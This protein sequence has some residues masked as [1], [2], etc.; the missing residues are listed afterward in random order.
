MQ[1]AYGTDEAA[2]G[3]KG[4]AGAEGKAAN[5]NLYAEH[6][7]GTEGAVLSRTSNLYGMLT[8][9]DPF[10]Y[11]GGIGAAVRHLDGKA[12]EL[13]IS[14]LRGVGPN[15]GAG[16]VE[17]ADA[18]LA[19]ELATRD[20]H[21]GY[22]K[23]LM[24]EG[25]AG[26]LQVLDSVNNFTGWTTVSREIVRDDQWQEF[27]DVYVRD[28]HQ[29]GLKNWFEKNN[30]HALA[31]TMEKMLEMARQG[32]WKADA[33]TVAE[34]K[35]RYKELAKR[36]DVQTD[37]QA[38][39]NFVAPGFGLARNAA[40]SLGAEP[41]AKRRRSGVAPG[42]RP[43]APAGNSRDVAGKGRQHATAHPAA[44]PLWR[45]A[46][47]ADDAGRRPG[48][49]KAATAGGGMKMPGNLRFTAPRPA[50]GLASRHSKH[51]WGMAFSALLVTAPL[52]AEETTTLQ[53]VTV[54]ASSDAL[55]ERQAAATQK[56][57]ID[58]AEIEALGGLS[59]GETI[60]K[61]PGIDA[62]CS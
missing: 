27:V 48:D 24:A 5:V 38:F 4:I 18:F 31:Q 13:Y 32:Y 1:F 58:R 53:E 37:N 45:R 10:Q 42:R 11:L 6:L 47:A 28:K 50:R 33:K 57:I 23:G 56:T 9:D 39:K 46:G 7:K 35:E 19:K 61:L 2:W 54:T 40:R 51:P 25:Y 26:T 30:P 3:S 21:P 43:A 17:G 34:L 55:G 22:I 15:A 20:F 14:N 44:R 36:H 29:L 59:I 8:T 60:R 16:K 52:S 12:P 41:A 62:G 49:G